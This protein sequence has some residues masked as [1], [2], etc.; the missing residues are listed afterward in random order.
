MAAYILT[1][2]QL[3]YVVKAYFY[4]IKNDEMSNNDRNMN[5]VL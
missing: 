5:C 4:N 2:T 1:L 3:I